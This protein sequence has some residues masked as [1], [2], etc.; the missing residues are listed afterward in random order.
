MHASDVTPEI[1][2]H[3]NEL[4]WGSDRSVNHI[5][6]ELD[7]SKGALYTA[8]K[9]LSSG[10]SCPLCGDEVGWPNRTARDQ[11]K[12]HCASCAWSGSESQTTSYVNT[13]RFKEARQ[14]KDDDVGMASDEHPL[15]PPDTFGGSGFTRIAGGA[16]LGAAVGLALVLWVRRR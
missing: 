9:V 7:L 8:L 10:R 14:D 4:Y 16:L 3:A 15:S 5:A 2:A 12:L 6:E 11:D 1:A 13:D